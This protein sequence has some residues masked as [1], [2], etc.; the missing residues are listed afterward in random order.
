MMIKIKN[1]TN[2]LKLECNGLYYSPH[3]SVASWSLKLSDR[4]F[5]ASVSFYKIY[6]F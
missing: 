4:V 6:I 1:R 3:K 5:R 2:W